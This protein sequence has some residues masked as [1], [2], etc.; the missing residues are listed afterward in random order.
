LLLFLDLGSEIPD[1]G[2]IKISIRRNSF[3]K[4]LNGKFEAKKFK[5]YCDQSTRENIQL[6]KTW[7]SVSVIGYPTVFRIHKYLA[8]PD[9]E[10]ERIAGLLLQYLCE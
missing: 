7:N 6:I 5:F 9:P 2:W 1:L 10:P 4:Y 3:L 8:D